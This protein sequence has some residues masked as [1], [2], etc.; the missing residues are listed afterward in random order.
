[1]KKILKPITGAVALAGFIAITGFVTLAPRNLS[2]A[3]ESRLWIEG[4]STV[5][6]FTCAATKVNVVALAETESAPSDMVK[7]ASVTIPVA[8]LD[9]R[10]ETMNGHMRKALKATENPQIAWKLSSY[11]VEGMN[12]VMTG[13][14]SI[15]GKENPMELRATGSAES[16][17]TIRVKGSKEFRMTEFGVKPPSLMLGTMKVRDP[18]KVWFDFVLNP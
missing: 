10:N 14:L 18:V 3:R 1:M 11:R 6:S 5:K 16:N 8:S 2:L 13:T 15:A 17:G 9:C 12:V 4:T 7:S